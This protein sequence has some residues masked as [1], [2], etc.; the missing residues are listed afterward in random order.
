MTYIRFISLLVFSLWIKTAYPLFL[1]ELPEQP[2]TES[3]V[4]GLNQN[5]PEVCQVLTKTLDPALDVRY[6]IGTG[7]LITPRLVITAAHVVEVNNE[8]SQKI[9]VRFGREKYRAIEVVPYPHGRD[10]A[11][12]VLE[13]AVTHI[14]PRLM[15][16]LESPAQLAEIDV[17]GYGSG[18]VV[19]Q[20][21]SKADASEAKAF[22]DNAYRN[23]LTTHQLPTFLFHA[24]QR[25]RPEIACL[26]Q[27]NMN[28]GCL[29][30]GGLSDTEHPNFSYKL[31]LSTPEIKLGHGDSGA[32][33]LDHQQ[34][35]IAIAHQ[36]TVSLAEH[37][38]GMNI[39]SMARKIVG[40]KTLATF[41]AF[42]A[43]SLISLPYIYGSFDFALWYAVSITS[44]LVCRNFLYTLLR[45]QSFKQYG[46]I[47]TARNQALRDPEKIL[48][49]KIER[50][51]PSSTPSFR[52]FFM[53]QKGQIPASPPKAINLRGNVA[54]FYEPITPRVISW[55][56]KVNKHYTAQNVRTG[57][58]LIQSFRRGLRLFLK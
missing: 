55:A 8:F 19:Y 49:W 25:L 46:R 1:I 54:S 11:I 26:G 24:K 21:T 9:I 15:A 33:L 37:K 32:P 10:I 31:I 27:M 14:K 4:S 51:A 53:T 38:W 23:E 30:E 58:L 18:G 39:A 48:S 20:D 45:K 12:L 34:R 41:L 5:F 56:D 29:V 43:T 22:L 3:E 52:H 28:E 17:M 40:K 13:E 57:G 6:D 35:L 47:S 44:G 2:L 36:S 7:T 16:P 42:N 50:R